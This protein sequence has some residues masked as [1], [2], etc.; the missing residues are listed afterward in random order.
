LTTPAK[1]RRKHKNKNGT[2]TM[3]HRTA[4]RFDSTQQARLLQ[5]LG[6]ARAALIAAAEGMPR[7]SV[8]R[9]SLE[10]LVSNIDDAAQILTGNREHFWRRP[11]ATPGE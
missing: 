2:S 7:K 3:A 4:K 11:H 6:E 10:L 9:A 5:T 8:P 1:W